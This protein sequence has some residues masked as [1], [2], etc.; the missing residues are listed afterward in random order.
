MYR[1]K[2][3]Y[4]EFPKIPDSRGALTF[5]EGENTV[6]FPIK[7]VYYIYNIPGR[8]TKRGGH[9]HRGVKEVIIPI[10]GSFEVICDKGFEKTHFHMLQ[11]NMGLYVPEMTW[12]ELFN[13]SKN[14][15]CLVLSSEYYN[16]ANYVRKYNMFMREV[17]KIDRSDKR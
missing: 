11:H 12:V 2:P 1:E 3:R 15:I 13:F 5:I 7:R 17:K 14:V 16:E 9:A 6:P 10:S 4:I 8:E